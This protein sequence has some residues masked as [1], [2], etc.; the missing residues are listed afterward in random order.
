MVMAATAIEQRPRRTESAERWQAALRRAIAAGIE[1]LQIAGTGEWVV[2]S[3]TR[4]GTVYR[5]TPTAC[6][7]EAAFAGDPCC[8]HRAV[9]RQVLGYFDRPQ[10]EPVE[11]AAAIDCG[12]CHGRGW[13]YAEAMGGRTF[14][15][16][17]ACHRCGGSGQMPVKLR[18]LAPVANLN[19]AAD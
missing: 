16:K 4:I 2:T 12:A 13:S 5:V 6:E 3:S 14:P 9:I 10:L 7:C 18:T 19:A 1:P 17:V 15:D 11:T 8:V